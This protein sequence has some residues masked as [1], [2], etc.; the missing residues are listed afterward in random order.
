MRGRLSFAE[1]EGWLQ[2]LH[3]AIIQLEFAH[4]S[5]ADGA[6]QP[7]EF[8]AAL[9]AALHSAGHDTAEHTERLEELRRSEDA[10]AAKKEKLPTISFDEFKAFQMLVLYELGAVERALSMFSA[11]REERH[12]FARPEFRRAVRA[13]LGPEAELSSTLL[14]TLW[15]VMGGSASADSRIAFA[16]FFGA[17]RCRRWQGGGGGP[18]LGGVL[19]CCRRCAM[20]ALFPALP[21]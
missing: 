10:A 16:D 5:R 3:A 15:A 13:T 11:S 2:R 19:G 20:A 1:F 21:A 9:V 4:Y 7:S 12:S 8:A 14:D 17:L 18:K 6:M